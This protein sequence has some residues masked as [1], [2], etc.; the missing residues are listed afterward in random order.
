MPNLETTYLG[1]ELSCPLVAAASPLTGH[2]DS[3]RALEDAGIAALTLPSLFEEQVEHEATAAQQLATYGAEAF[4]EAVGGY[5]PPSTLGVDIIS[6]H[7]AAPS[8]SFGSAAEDYLNHIRAVKAAV[9][10]PVIASMNGT[11]TGGW[12]EFARLIQ[13]AGADALELNIY[14]VAA[15]PDVTGRDVEQ[16]FID[17]T[18]SVRETLEIPLAVKIPPFFSAPGHTIR[19]IAAAGARSVV[20]FNRFVQP[21]IDLD[22]LQVQPALKLSTSDELRLTL[23]W[24]AIL[25]GRVDC[26][27]AATTGA[28]DDQDVLKLLFAGARVVT[29]ASALLQ[30]GP[31]H[32]AV[33]RRALEQWL[34]ARD[35]ASIDQLR[36]S[37]SQ[38]NSPDPVAFERANYMKALLNYS[39]PPHR[40]P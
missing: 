15:D 24:M 19:A 32:V 6:G 29:L 36:G 31:K 5:F 37:L 17:I 30:K 16:R 38:L 40:S 21:D 2:L 7:T 10:I 13:D 33:L 39:S 12:L 3:V 20:L 14:Y 11:T 27:L 23:R 22:E 34:E 8:Y 18:R 4:G 26:E 1:F 35:Y 28:H 9:D 25:F